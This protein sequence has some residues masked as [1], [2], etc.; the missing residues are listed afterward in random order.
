MLVL[1]RYLDLNTRI[2]R[3]TRIYA[4][5][6]GCGDGDDSGGGCGGGGGGRDDGQ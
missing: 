3:S 5:E 4:G 2:C 6:G 1:C